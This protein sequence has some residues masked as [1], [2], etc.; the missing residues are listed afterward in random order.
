[1]RLNSDC[2][3]LGVYQLFPILYRK[4]N[5]SA[6]KNMR[7]YFDNAMTHALM[8]LAQERFNSGYDT[9]I[10]KEVDNLKFM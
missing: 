3:S 5:F 2:E 1:M 7:F 6:A 4:G 8:V 10:I 9:K